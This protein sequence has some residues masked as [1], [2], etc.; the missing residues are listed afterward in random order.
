MEN[1]AQ[2]LD[3]QSKA[4]FWHLLICAGVSASKKYLFL[5][6]LALSC[7]LYVPQAWAAASNIMILN[8]AYM[9]FLA[10]RKIWLNLAYLAYLV[11]GDVPPRD[12][13]WVLS[14]LHRLGSP[15]THKPRF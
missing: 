13:Q 3:I 6:Y 4:S 10:N 11:K 8:M 2:I 7:L 5:Q 14:E 1:P 9:A 12:G 15:R